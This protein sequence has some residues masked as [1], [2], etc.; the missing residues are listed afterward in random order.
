MLTLVFFSSALFELMTLINSELKSCVV[1]GDFNIDLVKFGNHDKKTSDYINNIF[2]LGFMPMILKPTR[3]SQ[4]S[5]TLIDHIYSNDIFSSSTSGL[6]VTDVADNLGVFFLVIDKLDTCSSQN[7]HEEPIKTHSM[8]PQNTIKLK[9]LLDQT[10]FTEISQMDCPDEVYNKFMQL[11]KSDFYSSFP[12]KSLKPNKLYVK[13]EPWVTP[14]LLACLRIKTKLF[15][16]KLNKP[17][18]SNINNLKN[19]NNIVSSQRLRGFCFL[20][21][22]QFLSHSS[23]YGSIFSLQSWWL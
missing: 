21:F 10:D 16:K 11:Y 18:Q 17:T 1:M 7:K 20:Y 6:I 4:T 8:S 5:A 19:Y 23:T 2:P 12:L 9:H 13:R 3:I 15:P 22:A 14:E